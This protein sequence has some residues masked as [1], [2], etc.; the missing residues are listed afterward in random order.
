MEPGGVV[1]KV[2]TK[3]VDK[4]PLREIMLPAG[5]S[6]PDGTT[7]NL[8]FTGVSAEEK[9][10]IVYVTYIFSRVGETTEYKEWLDTMSEQHW[11]DES[12]LCREVLDKIVYDI[13]TT[14][15]L[16]MVKIIP[17]IDKFME[18]LGEGYKKMFKHGIKHKLETTRF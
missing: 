5:G 18:L 6:C 7:H 17:V 14:E 12:K 11:K 9:K 15:G 10:G 13:A 1:F 4:Q 8:I 3:E 2:L 16:D